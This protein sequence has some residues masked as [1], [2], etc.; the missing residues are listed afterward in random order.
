[1][2][3]VSIAVRQTFKQP[4]HTLLIIAALGL[5][6][7]LNAAVYGM[8]D[9]LLVNPFPFPNAQR[10]AVVGDKRPGDFGNLTEAASP[11]NFLDWRAQSSG[12]GPIAEM[13][14]FDWW[15]ANLTGG[16]EPERIQACA[17]TPGFFAM[18]G[19]NIADGREFLPGEDTPGRHRVVVLSRGLWERRFGSDRSIVGRT[20]QIDGHAY[21]V[22]GIGPDEFSFPFGTEA[23][24]PLAFEA[25]DTA[26]RNSRHL[27]A[28]ARLAPGATFDDA[29]AHMSVVA[30]N[31][32]AAHPTENAAFETLVETLADGVGDAGSA[33]LIVVWQVS[34]LIVL[35]IACANIA[36]LL[37]ARGA[38]RAREMAVR[39]A[40]GANRWRIVRQL[41]VESFVLAA[42]AVPVALGLAWW[43]IRLVRVNMPPRIA[44]M[45]P[46]WNEMQVDANVMLVTVAAAVVTSLLF[47]LLPALQSSSLTLVDTLKEG[48]RGST[49][50]RMRMR[51]VLVAA[52]VALA[53]PLLVA[54]GMT[55]VGTQRF[56]NGPQGYDPDGL[57]VFRLT[58]PE[59]TYPDQ[60]ARVQ[61]TERAIDAFES[62]PGVTAVAATN[63]IPSS[64]SNWRVRYELEGQPAATP[65]DRPRADYRTIT[66]G[67]FDT[68]RMPITRG[69]AFTR[70]DRAESQLVA[71]VSDSFAER[72]WPGE[73]P[74]GKRVVLPGDT[75]ATLTI[76]GTA[77]NH[78]HD[79]FLGPH[80]PT[81]YRPAAQAMPTAQGFVLRT[82]GD[83]SSL[84][85]L[86]RRALAA[87]DP[88][89]PIY[90]VSTQRQ[91]LKERTIGPQYAAAMMALFGVIA[92]LLSVVGL[93]ALIGYYVEQRRQEIGVRMALGA[94]RRDILRQ[95]L[96]QAATLAGIGVVIGVA[97]AWATGRLLESA[98]F[99]IAQHDVRLLAFF[100]CAL[101]AAALLA[102]YV[103]ARRAATLDPL[104][105]MRE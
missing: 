20:V 89:Q 99:G 28:I 10:L 71:I 75:T 97:A 1:M 79:W 42:L 32:K 72:H 30:A 88:A 87:I 48:A 65:N 17:V 45:V 105:A 13:G 78:I 70:L 6:L 34:A 36:S 37:L 69:R 19:I 33:T 5:G 64:S 53:L 80:V 12:G 76:V 40:I 60:T 67:W 103:P 9:A 59:S 38:G 39:L 68:M 49:G 58:L 104:A 98:F 73:D 25:A 66:P 55:A 27:T 16:D 47:G 24:V 41:M 57:L 102:A 84:A 100:A 74:L 85:P 94:G 31:L 82:T 81:I 54:A 93:Y 15:S 51:R 8:G 18:L 46:G 4:A 43:V 95:M 92:L 2:G 23:W 90:Q 61:F 7:G 52:E 86:A 29:R 14:A 3:D 91:L 22:V 35:L 11:A 50:G 56:L 21:T 83:P 96:R 26:D 77:A 101:S 63:I 44:Q 62:L